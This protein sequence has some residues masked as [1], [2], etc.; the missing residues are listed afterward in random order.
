MT[1]Y[2]LQAMRWAGS[3]QINLAKFLGSVL[4]LGSN[5]NNKKM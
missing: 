3:A 2:F 1:P 5:L 4:M